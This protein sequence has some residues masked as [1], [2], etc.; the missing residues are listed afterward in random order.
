MWKPNVDNV[1]SDP[2]KGCGVSDNIKQAH[3]HAHL[4]DE[5]SSNEQVP[6]TLHTYEHTYTYTYIHTYLMD[7]AKLQ[8][9]Y[10]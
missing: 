2:R 8:Q 4:L 10:T 7:G 3:S 6:T 5:A 1:F 9:L